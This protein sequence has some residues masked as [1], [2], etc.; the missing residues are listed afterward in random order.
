MKKLEDLARAKYEIE[1]FL[2]QAEQW[3]LLQDS[4]FRAELLSD[5]CSIGLEFG[6]LIFAF[7]NDE[8]SESWRVLGY[9]INEERLL[10][11]VSRQLGRISAQIELCPVEMDTEVAREIQV[12][13]REY[14]DLICDV[15]LKTFPGWRI[16]RAATRRDDWR[17]LSGIYTRLLLDKRGEKIVAIGVNQ[18]E[19]QSA[20][21]RLLSS[22]LVWHDRVNQRIP[23]ENLR[24]LALFAPAGRA[25]ALAQRMTALKTGAV[26]LELYEVEEAMGTASAVRP[27]DQGDLIEKSAKDHIWPEYR[28]L[29]PDPIRDQIFALAPD[30]ITVDQ[31]PTSSYES[32]RVRGLEFARVYKS[33]GVAQFG[34]GDSRK[35][36]TA[37][38]FPDLARLVGEIISHRRADAEDK[39]HPFYT[40]QAERWLEEILR[41]DIRALDSTLDPRYVYAQI[42]AYRG[43]ERGMIDLLAVNNNRRLVVIELKVT[44]DIDL[45]MQGLD[46][47]L[48]VEWHRKRNDFRRRGYFAGIELSDESPMLYLVAPLFRFHRTLETVARWIDRRAQVFRIGITENW[49]AGIK[50]LLRESLN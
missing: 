23:S 32:L 17:Q 37:A 35:Q 38:T 22:A 36:L 41:N 19:S 34:I 46:Y 12:R 40:L 4:A 50:V 5:N 6:K 3:R 47:W 15:A 31:R 42:P 13:R 43:D 10:L 8:L 11:S 20:I 33:K 9:E 24:R 45:P 7:W 28:P 39:Q 2:L 44:E 21:N 16:E 18:Q 48:R 27:F 49:R 26:E 25:L 30:S 29:K 14:H 1:L